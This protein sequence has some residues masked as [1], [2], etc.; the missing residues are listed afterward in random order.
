MSQNLIWNSS[1]AAKNLFLVV[2]NC[3]TPKE[4]FLKPEYVRL[5]VPSLSFHSTRYDSPSL[6]VP[7]EKSLIKN[8]KDYI[9]D[10]EHSLWQSKYRKLEK[11]KTQIH[12]KN[13]RQTKCHSMLI[14]PCPISTVSHCSAPEPR[15]II[16]YPRSRMIIQPG[17]DLSIDSCRKNKLHTNK[18]S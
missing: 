6:L 11:S 14:L 10:R 2:S 4:R 13:T 1:P 18:E 17:F 9:L 8:T 7:Q 15:S 12:I 16:V 3:T 5:I